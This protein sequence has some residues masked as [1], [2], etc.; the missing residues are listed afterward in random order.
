VKLWSRLFCVLVI[1]PYLAA[2]AATCPPA[3]PQLA[4]AFAFG[5]TRDVKAVSKY[6]ASHDASVSGE[7]ADH[8]HHG[9]PSVLSAQKASHATHHDHAA[10]TAASND[11]ADRQSVDSNDGILRAPCKCGCG[12]GLAAV[13]TASPSLGNVLIS[14][15]ELPDTSIN[16]ASAS[17][18][19]LASHED[20]LLRP[21][22]PVPIAS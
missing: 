3:D 5:L 12:S 13:E 4:A 1:G 2:A 9:P 16:V 20:A 11:D 17:T 18:F 15:D 10:M 8:A 21:S 19:D 6:A 14:E 22:E 7:H